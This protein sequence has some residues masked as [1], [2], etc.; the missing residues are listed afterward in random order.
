MGAYST[1]QLDLRAAEKGQKGGRGGI[2]PPPHHQFL[3]LPLSNAM[4]VLANNSSMVTL[5]VV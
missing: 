3:D 5:Q 4:P 2:T 1:P